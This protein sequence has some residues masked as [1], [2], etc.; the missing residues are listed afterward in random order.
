MLYEV[1]TF[2]TVGS[3][4]KQRKAQL[5]ISLADVGGC[6]CSQII[7]HFGAGAGHRRFG[8]SL[9]LM[10]QALEWAEAQ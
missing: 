2:E 8:C 3:E 6:S 5:G 10:R 4:Q 1:I 9:G 7:D